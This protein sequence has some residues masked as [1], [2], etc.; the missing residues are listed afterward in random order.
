MC[1]S[2]NALMLSMCPAG[3]APSPKSAKS[4]KQQQKLKK[5]AGA[6]AVA[7]GFKPVDLFG[8]KG[9]SAAAEAGTKAAG[10]ANKETALV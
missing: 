6:S 7:R 1:G 9:L 2:H 4:S 8:S 5:Q 10:A 3:S